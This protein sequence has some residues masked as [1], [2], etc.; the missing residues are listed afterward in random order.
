MSRPSTGRNLSASSADYL[1]HREQ[2]TEIASASVESSHDRPALDGPPPCV[3]LREPR[4]KQLY[5]IRNAKAKQCS[6]G[7]VAWKTASH[8][9]LVLGTGY[10][11]ACLAFTKSKVALIFGFLFCSSTRSGATQFLRGCP[12]RA[13]STTSGMPS[14]RRTAQ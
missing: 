8:S 14:T 9:G 13:H 10:G 3:Y 7:T 2:V 11:F 6:V 1:C 5:N 12:Q 4:R